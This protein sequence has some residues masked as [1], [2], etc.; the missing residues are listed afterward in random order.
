M[1][2]QNE[3]IIIRVDSKLKGEFK[4]ICDNNH[5]TISSRLKYLMKMDSKNKIKIKE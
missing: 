4:E 2:K 5:M 1:D 3:R